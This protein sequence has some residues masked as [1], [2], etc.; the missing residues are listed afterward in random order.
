MAAAPTTVAVRRR[1]R[2][3][4]DAAPLLA[5]DGE[6]PLFLA[7]PEPMP[8][9]TILGIDEGDASGP[10]WAFEVRRVADGVIRGPAG[11]RGCFGRRI[12]ADLAAHARRVGSE[13]LPSGAAARARVLLWRPAVTADGT[14]VI[15]FDEVADPAPPTRRRRGRARA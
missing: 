10:P 6:H 8:V 5:V 4:R 14:S 15:A 1:G 7:L 2:S 9:G 3:L 13:H 11:L 12:A